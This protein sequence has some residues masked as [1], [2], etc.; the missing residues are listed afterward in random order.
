MH[1]IVKRSEIS[2]AMTDTLNMAGTQHAVVI[3]FM[4]SLISYFFVP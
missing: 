4:I 3:K 1:V 2:E